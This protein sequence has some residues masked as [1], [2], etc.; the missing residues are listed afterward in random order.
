MHELKEQIINFCMPVL[1]WCTALGEPGLFVLAFIEASF[2]LLPPEL[3]LT[4]MV[5]RGINDPYILAII[6]TIGS[7][8][9]AVFG[10]YLGLFGGRP[11]ALRV[12]SSKAEWAINKAEGFFAK[13]GNAAI[14][15][16]AFTPIPYKVFTI[17][18]GIS[19]MN[20]T[21]FI[22]YSLLGRGTR[23][24]IFVYLLT[25]YGEIVLEN[26]FKLTLIGV[27]IYIAY[28]LTKFLLKKLKPN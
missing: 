23:Y 4:P 18:A 1:D 8:M 12:L 16:A 14:L 5:I 24:L 28:E 21:S 7:V 10:Y 20:M 15:I 11:V 6:T 25:C 26:F 2:F 13:Y 3:L 27:L 22:L 9:G 19:R 17:T